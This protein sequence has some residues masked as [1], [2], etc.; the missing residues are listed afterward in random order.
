MLTELKKTKANLNQKISQTNKNQEKFKKERNRANNAIRRR[1]AFLTKK[2][3]LKEEIEIM[4]AK[5]SSKNVK[6]TKN[7]S[8]STK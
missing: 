2:A 7:K 5:G 6:T 3:L 1:K 4:N 8:V